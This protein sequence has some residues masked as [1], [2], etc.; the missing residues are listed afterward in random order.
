LCSHVHLPAQSGSDR[1]LS[2][3][4]RRYTRADYLAIVSALKA[5]RPDVQITSDLIVGFPGETKEE[6]Q[7][8][9]SLMREVEYTERY[10]FILSPRPETSAAQ[11]PD[12]VSSHE[13]KDRLDELLALQRTLSRQY[14][15]SMVGSQQPVLVEGVS[16]R[17]DQLFGRTSSNRVVNFSG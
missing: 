12:E 7:E 1:V 9:L 6:F 4:N 10:S 3:M 5:A 11:L 14:S 2:L 8:T 17:G 16:R 15:L 13:K